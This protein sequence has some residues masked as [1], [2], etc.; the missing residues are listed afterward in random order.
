ML[1]DPKRYG[2][3]QI[4]KRQ[5]QKTEEKLK[6][7]KPLLNQNKNFLLNSLRNSLKKLNKIICKY[8]FEILLAF[9][10]TNF[11]KRNKINFKCT[12]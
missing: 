7:T 5:N 9:F 3:L 4:Q 11:E 8:L 6:I 2:N 1:V 10:E 12:V